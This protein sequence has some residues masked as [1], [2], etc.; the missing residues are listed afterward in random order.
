M[1]KEL[2]E[3]FNDDLLKCEIIASVEHE[4]IK[5]SLLRWTA[6]GTFSFAA[7]IKPT[8]KLIVSHQWQKQNE[9]DAR[10]YFKKWYEDTFTA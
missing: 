8:K 6:A 4:D 3:I 10:A 9:D 2:E 5:A 1:N 7:V